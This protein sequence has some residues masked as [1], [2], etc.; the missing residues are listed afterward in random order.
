MASYSSRYNE[1]EIRQLDFLSQFD[2]EFRHI[3]GADNEVADALSRIELNSLQ[4]ANGIDYEEMADAQ[5]HEG[6][7]IGPD[8]TALAVVSAFSDLRQHQS[9]PSPAST[10]MHAAPSFRN[11]L[12]SLALW[13]SRNHP[14]SG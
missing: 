9:F 14:T 1:R 5:Q 6:I 10:A 13:Y 8:D 3:R 7:R 11:G 4:L 12:W 2:L